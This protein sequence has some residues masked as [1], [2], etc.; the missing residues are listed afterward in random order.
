MNKLQNKI[1][2]VCVIGLGYVGLTLAVKLAE[3]NFNVIGIEKNIGI[4]NKI[5]KGL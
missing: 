4:L 1:N 5:K 2:N 3:K